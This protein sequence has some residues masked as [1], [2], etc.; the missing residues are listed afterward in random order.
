MKYLV[1]TRKIHIDVVSDMGATALHYAAMHNAKNS[2][3][4]LLSRGARHSRMHGGLTPF[5]VALRHEC[6]K[7]VSIFIGG[8]RANDSDLR[9]EHHCTKPRTVRPAPAIGVVNV[10]AGAREPAIPWERA[11]DSIKFW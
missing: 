8:T 10:P 11:L 1:D 5:L 3:K 9:I 2:V 6:N 7:V 4:F